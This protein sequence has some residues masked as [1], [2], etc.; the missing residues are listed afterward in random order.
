MKLSPVQDVIKETN[1]IIFSPHFDD[2]LFML[3]G[4]INALKRSSL[5]HT[6]NF[7]VQMIF[8]RSNYLAGSRKLNFDNSLDR[9]KLVT[10]KRLLEDQ[11]CLDALIGRFNYRYELLGENECFTRGK[12][13]ADSEME[14]PHGMYKD[15]DAQDHEIFARMKERIHQWAQMEDA[16][17]VFP[18]AIKEHID[19]FIVREAAIDVARAYASV[20]KAAFYFQEDKPY[21]GIATADELQRLQDFINGYNLQ[22]VTYAADA[23]YIIELAFTHYVSQVEEVYKKGIRQRAEL[24]AAEMHSTEACDRIY[25]L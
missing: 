6:K 13:F 15:F 25:K 9:V 22:P 20:N 5:L 4:Y 14:F 3:G 8:S 7:F 23:E 12:G 18:T 1:I 2:V 19:H 24:I 16:A 17:L 21:G 11:E 10:G